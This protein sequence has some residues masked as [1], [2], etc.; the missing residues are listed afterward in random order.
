MN[1][2]AALSSAPTETSTTQPEA[3]AAPE[4]PAT[5]PEAPAITP[6]QVAQYLGTTPETLTQFQD[7]SKNNGGLD[8][9]F[10]NMKKIMA[11]RQPQPQAQAPAPGQSPLNDPVTQTPPSMAEQAIAGGI[12]PQEFLT[13]QYFQSLASQE[14]YANI[15]DQIS[16]GEILKEMAKFNIQPLVN[17]QF[18]GK[19]IN[20]FLE[21]YSKT[22]PAKPTEP[23]V[24]ATP[25]VDYIQIPGDTITNMNQAMSVLAQDREFRAMG[26]AGHPLAEV[27]NKF[28]DDTMNAQANRG[29]RPSQ[30][31]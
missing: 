3:P 5:P 23:A 16:S 10:S 9:A 1:E 11:N 22:V 15:A 7:Y 2:E 30:K 4:T 29:K 18:N 14:K 13:Q 12:T 21:L 20:D 17:G 8:K 25:T 28:F 27:A 31:K 24:T 19:Q 6:E 26:R